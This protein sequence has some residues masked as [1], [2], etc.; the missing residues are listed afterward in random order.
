MKKFRS[1]NR[2]TDHKRS[3]ERE[4]EDVVSLRIT[5]Q[6]LILLQKLRAAAFKSVMKSGLKH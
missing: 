4:L 3:R 2:S 5:A 6:E 1:S